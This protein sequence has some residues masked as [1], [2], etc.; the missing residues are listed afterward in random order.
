MYTDHSTQCAVVA[1]DAELTF[2]ACRIDQNHFIFH[3]TNELIKALCVQLFSD[4]ADAS[5]AGLPLL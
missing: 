4:G 3:L 1:V 5:L 2:A